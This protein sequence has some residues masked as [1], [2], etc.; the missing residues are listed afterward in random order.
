MIF[1]GLVSLAVLLFAA[2]VFA[3]PKMGDIS[4]LN[5]N[6]QYK[7]ELINK[8][9]NSG[10]GMWTIVT[11]VYDL[12]SGSSLGSSTESRKRD[13]IVDK[14]VIQK[15]LKNCRQANGTPE[16]IQ[17]PAGKFATCK[18]AVEGGHIW[19]GDVPFGVIR[20]ST[21]KAQFELMSFKNGQ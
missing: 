17:V 2:N 21:D 20:Q 7:I 16:Q 9:F 13:E 5:M 10:T 15:V 14:N 1:R 12:K 4:V 18:L 6:N 19:V 8:G 11:N 3:Y